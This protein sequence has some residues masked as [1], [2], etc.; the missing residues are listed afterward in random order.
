[1]KVRQRGTLWVSLAGLLSSFILSLIV[2][3]WGLDSP[4]EFLDQNGVYRGFNVDMLNAVFLELEM[5]YE[6]IP[7]KWEEAQQALRRGE[8]DM[9]QGMI[10]TPEREGYYLFADP[11]VTNAQATHR[12]NV[13][14]HRDERA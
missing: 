3:F 2:F 10:R 5:D 13:V 14:E 4:Y 11:L 7:M 6:L 12:T 1:M 9:I 8:V